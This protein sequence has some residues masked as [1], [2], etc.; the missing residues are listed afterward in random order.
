MAMNRSTLPKQMMPGRKKP[1][2]PKN[3]G[4][5]L[6]AGIGKAKTNHGKMKMFNKGGHVG[7][8]G[9]LLTM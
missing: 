4:G 1:M 2:K 8:K 9:G 7:M 6:P 5:K 3:M